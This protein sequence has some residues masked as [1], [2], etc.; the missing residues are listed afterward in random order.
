MTL[1]GVDVTVVD[2]QA[3]A[4]PSNRSLML[5][6][7]YAQQESKYR[8]VGGRWGAFDISGGAVNALVKSGDAYASYS[9]MNVAQFTSE[10]QRLRGGRR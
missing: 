1:A 7:E 4:L 8:L 5:F 6:L 9:R 10:I 3:T 2:E